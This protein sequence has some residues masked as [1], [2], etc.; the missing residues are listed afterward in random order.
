[1]RLA[2]VDR[3][4]AESVDHLEIMAEHI[5]VLVIF[6]RDILP[7]G[8]G[9]GDVRRLA[10]RQRELVAAGV[11]DVSCPARTLDA[12]T[13]GDAVMLRCDSRGHVTVRKRRCF[14]SQ[15]FLEQVLGAI[16][17]RVWRAGSLVA[18]GTG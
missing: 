17:T 6:R 9:E 18:L 16:V 10:E 11:H 13:D 3:I 4:A 8:S 15:L 2:D 7:E 14:T 1:M 12:E 5:R